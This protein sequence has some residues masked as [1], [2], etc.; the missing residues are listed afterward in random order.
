MSGRSLI[1][2]VSFAASALLQ[3]AATQNCGTPNALDLNSGTTDACDNGLA[4]GTWTCAGDFAHGASSAGVCNLA[5]GY[6]RLDVANGPGSCASFILQ[7]LI[8]ATSFGPGT[9]YESYCD[10]EC[11]YCTFANANFN[12][13]DDEAGDVYLGGLFDFSLD[14]AEREHFEFAVGMLNDKTDGWYDTVLPASM[15]INARVLDVGCDHITATSA[16]W[17][18]AQNW[19]VPDITGGTE[20]VQA[21]LHGVIGP[22]CEAASKGVGTLSRLQETPTISARETSPVL[23]D[24]EAYSHFF[25]T[26]GP[27]GR[28]GGQLKA[29]LGWLNWNHVGLLFTDTPESD[30]IAREFLNAWGTPQSG[31]PFVG[32]LYAQCKVATDPSTN[33]TN[34]T[35]IQQCLYDMDHLPKNQRPRAIVLVASN[36]HAVQIIREAV[37]SQW[38]DSRTWIGMRGWAEDSAVLG[39]RSQATFLALRPKT[40]AG[41]FGYTEYL[42]KWQAYQQNT[43]AWRQRLNTCTGT[44]DGTIA[45]DCSGTDDGTGATCALNSTLHGCTV[46]DGDC[47]YLPVS[48]AACALDVSASA[49][50]VAGGDCV[51]TEGVENELA[52]SCAETADAVVAMAMAMDA[53]RCDDAVMGIHNLENGARVK[54]YLQNVSFAGVSGDI[55]F[56]GSGDRATSKFWISFSNPSTTD[57]TAW[58]DVAMMSTTGSTTHRAGSTPAGPP[59]PPSASPIDFGALMFNGALPSDSYADDSRCRDGTDCLD[60]ALPHCDLG[61]KAGIVAE[62][63]EPEPNCEALE[64][65]TCVAAFQHRQCVAPMNLFKDSAGSTHHMTIYDDVTTSCYQINA[66][67]HQCRLN[68]RDQPEIPE[69]DNYVA[70][71]CATYLPAFVG[72]EEV[73][74]STEMQVCCRQDDGKLTSWFRERWIDYDIKFGQCTNCLNTARRMLCQTACDEQNWRMHTSSKEDIP[75]VAS[76]AVSV[77]AAGKDAAVCRSFCDMAFEACREV[78]WRDEVKYLYVGEHASEVFCATA[79]KIEVVPDDVWIETSPLNPTTGVFGVNDADPLRICTDVSN[80]EAIHCAGTSSYK[81]TGWAGALLCIVAV[82]SEILS[83]KLTARQMPSVSVTLFMGLVLGVFIDQVI[84]PMEMEVSGTHNLVNTVMLKP[85]AFSSFLLP[86]VIFSSAF[87]MEHHVTVFMWLTIYKISVFAVLSTIL[88]IFTVG[89]MLIAINDSVDGLLDHEM[90]FSDAM[91]YASLLTAIDP[92]STLAGFARVGVDPRLYSLIYGE[93]IINRVV[94]IVMFG[95]FR[96]LADSEGHF[97]DPM[98]AAVEQFFFLFIGSTTCG[99]GSGVAVTLLF[100][101]FGHPPESAEELERMKMAG[102]T[103]SAERDMLEKLEGFE[104]MDRDKGGDVDMRDLTALDTDGDGNVSAAE[105]MAAAGRVDNSASKDQLHLKRHQ[106]MADAAVFFFS[107]LASFYIAEAVALSGIISALCCAVMCNQFAVRNMSFDARDY[108]RSFYVTLA[109][110]AEHVFMTWIGVLYYMANW[111]EQVK[112]EN[113][114]IQLWAFIC[115]IVSRVVCVLVSGIIVNL[116][117]LGG[118][119]SAGKISIKTM[120]MMMGTGLKGAVALALVTKMPTSS[121][122]QFTSATIFLIFWTNVLLGG[123]SIPL[124]KFLGIPNESD[125]TMDLEEFEFT[126]DEANYLSSLEGFFIKLE[127]MLLIPSADDDSFSAASG[128]GRHASLWQKKVDEAKARGA[129]QGKDRVAMTPEVKKAQ[130]KLNAAKFDKMPGKSAAAREQIILDLEKEL[131]RQTHLANKKIMDD[132]T[133]DTSQGVSDRSQA[134][135]NEDADNPMYGVERELTVETD[136]S[137][138]E[139]DK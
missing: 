1:V 55:G 63:G 136:F 94:A 113:S 85:E 33:A 71:M 133:W 3:L 37:E 134:A 108:A 88:S 20:P 110:I 123:L 105:S 117:F 124:I 24:T 120:I 100:R 95:V 28:N 7:G 126:E 60:P 40:N 50:A 92:V 29:V 67:Y 80:E 17:Q 86:I 112:T 129:S 5:C 109:E 61:C 26:I 82:V 96:Q 21:P 49:C 103:E 27:D 64:S 116:L 119:N 52:E 54:E 118:T 13:A 78:V 9:A 139:D 79:L 132:A 91:M 83:D 68:G 107:S 111:N 138:D 11:G 4:T 16:M 102:F 84:A 36:A 114:D 25:R 10:F 53:A 62:D 42:Q 30:G 22:G 130:K 38:D 128:R 75:I 69:P 57:P 44:N 122:E 6:N 46:L 58:S 87:N 35:S 12:C 15:T 51:Y 18:L 14:S 41:E 101:D 115:V 43:L 74:K 90:R 32:R 131:K 59:P 8:C 97:E 81:Y 106:A 98:F 121:G 89:G 104:A 70:G 65:G 34:L 45:A 56:D 48:G 77:V 72:G 137:G 19:M 73:D 2:R 76:D 31:T 93:S 23:S 135:E 127:S 99:L 125:G 39:L 47:Q 66:T